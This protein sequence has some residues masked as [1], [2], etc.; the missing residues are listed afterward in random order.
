MKQTTERHSELKEWQAAIPQIPWYYN[1]SKA[2]ICSKDEGTTIAS[3]GGDLKLQE[4]T[5][6]GEYLAHCANTLPVLIEA[7]DRLVKEIEVMP[8]WQRDE[9][10][11]NSWNDLHDAIK[12][13][14]AEHLAG[15]FPEHVVEQMEQELTRLREENKKLTAMATN[16]IEDNEKIKAALAK[17]TGIADTLASANAQLTGQLEQL[18]KQLAAE[19]G[20]PTMIT[21]PRGS[22]YGEMSVKREGKRIHVEH[23]REGYTLHFDD[24]ISFTRWARSL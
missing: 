23:T 24:E 18:K 14:R 6:A 22:E 5:A 17:E 19:A 13:A 4:I 11:F 16:Q 3:V 8:S 7:A 1:P 15:R 21:D 20:L 2:T 10:S 12:E 9:V